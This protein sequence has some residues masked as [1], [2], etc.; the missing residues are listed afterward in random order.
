[1]RKIKD[2]FKLVNRIFL[3][4][5][6]LIFSCTSTSGNSGTTGAVSRGKP[7]WVDNVNSVYNRSQYVASVG[8]AADRE[9]AEKNALTNLAAFFG[10]SIQADQTIINTYYEA[11]KNGATE[12]WIDNIAMRNAITTTVSMDTLIGAEIREI[13]HDARKNIY[14]TAAVMERSKTIQLYTEMISANLQMINNLTGM[15]QTEKNTLEGISRFQ[16]AATVADINISYA[17]LLRLLNAS[18]P[19]GVKRGDEYRIEA[20]NIIKTIPISIV[21]TGDREGRLQSAF[22]KVLTELRFKSGG[23][24]SRYVLR[25]NVKL[26][27]VD[28]PDNTEKH[29]LMELKANLTDNSTGEILLPFSF[30]IREGHT[31]IAVAE[32]RVFIS[33]ESRIEEEFGE[34]LSSYLSLLMPGRK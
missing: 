30:T 18:I 29:V 10:Q 24:N 2:R 6:L 33:A 15:N 12:G 32:N 11:V 3:F 22:A 1:L 19:N 25:V 13:W 27:T 5:L 20:Q 31:N 7:A 26:S 9:M 4:P 8:Y 16:F 17:N 21:V 23:N 14:Y 34:V 28:Y